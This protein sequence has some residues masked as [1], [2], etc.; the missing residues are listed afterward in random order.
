MLGTPM[1][2]IAGLL[3]QTVTFALVLLVSRRAELRRW[4]SR[5]AMAIPVLLA[6]IVA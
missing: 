6:A 3:A 4:A 1:G 5:V 2:L